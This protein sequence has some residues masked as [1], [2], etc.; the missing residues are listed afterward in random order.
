MG[1]VLVVDDDAELL[2]GICAVLAGAGHA[3]ERADGGFGALE[4]L[5]QGKP[6]DLLLTDVMMPGLHGLA[7]ARMAVLRRPKIK[8]LYLTGF[9]ELADGLEHGPRYGKMLHKPLLPDDLRREVDEAL[10]SS[11]REY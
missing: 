8:V 2:N 3:V 11:P 4:I 1:F 10:A 6:L 9:C 7:L 5:D